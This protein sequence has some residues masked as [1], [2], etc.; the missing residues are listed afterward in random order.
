MIEVL[1]FIFKFFTDFLKMLFTIDVGNGLTL[2]LVMC[3]VFIFFPCVLMVIN[4]LK[5][6][7]VD[8]LDDVY[9][10]REKQSKYL[11]KHTYEYKAK[12]RKRWFLWVFFY[13][14]Q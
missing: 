5:I 4:F 14:I 11:P 8:E 9:D 12:H 10:K 13:L 6:T 1:K 2:G 7:L 3:V